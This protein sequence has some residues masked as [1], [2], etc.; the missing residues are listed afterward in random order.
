MKEVFLLILALI[1]IIFASV[2]DLKKREVANW[3]NFSLIIFALGFRFFY[4]VFNPSNSFFGFNFLIQGLIGLGIFFVLGNL[5]YYGRIFA[6]GDAKLMIALGA[7]LPL[8]NSLFINLKIFAVFL[9]IFLVIGAIYGFIWSFVLVSKNTK[10]FKEEFFKIFKTNK[11][12]VYS[13]MI[14]GLLLMFLGFLQSLL[15]FIGVLVFILPC[16]FIYAKAIEEVSMVKQVPLKQLTEGD[17]LYEDLKIKVG[18]KNKIIKSKWEGL[19]KEEIKLIRK[20]YKNKTVKI[21]QGIAFVPV[22]LI[23]FIL[24]IILYFYSSFI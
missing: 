11:N 3:L 6:G 18:R 9:F 23:S 24:L 1:W 2:Q 5:F 7:I 20:K 12:K 22:F 17:W 14:L 19:N 4:S 10:D 15:L 16:L 8:S 21:K 13:T